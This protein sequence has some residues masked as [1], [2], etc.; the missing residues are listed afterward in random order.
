MQREKEYAEKLIIYN[1]CLYK[2]ILCSFNNAPVLIDMWE[3]RLKWEKRKKLQ[4]ENGK[5]K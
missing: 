5:C 1:L 3:F 2:F 4:A